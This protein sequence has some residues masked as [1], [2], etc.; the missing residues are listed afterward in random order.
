MTLLLLAALASATP[1]FECLTV[2][3]TVVPRTED[4]TLPVV[5]R[6]DDGVLVVNPTLLPQL[7]ASTRAVLEAQPC[8]PLAVGRALSL[9]EADCWAVGTL[10]MLE[11]LRRGEVPRVRGDLLRLTSADWTTIQGGP[12]WI[13]VAGCIMDSSHLL[14][15]TCIYSNDGSCDEPRLCDPGTDTTDCGHRELRQGQNRCAWAGDGV[16][17]EPYECAPGSDAA[18]CGHM[19]VLT[20]PGDSCSTAR[21]GTCDEPQRCAPGT[22]STDCRV[23]PGTDLVSRA[24]SCPYAGDGSCDEPRLCDPGTDSTDCRDGAPPA[25]LSELCLTPYG[26]CVVLQP[27]PAGSTCTCAAWPSTV[28]VLQ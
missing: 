8:A 17:D 9:A 1:A 5:A 28:G 13:D 27:E 21:D 24:D 20:S 7:S 14:R 3:G 4:P 16:C 18:D 15:D 19:H 6:M 11:V 22:D 23:R 2:D 25:P 12:R 26:G 10:S